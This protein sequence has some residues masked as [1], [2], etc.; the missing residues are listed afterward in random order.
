VQPDTT[1][2]TFIVA[3]VLCLVCS[4]LVS[5]AA[6]GL[7]PIQKRNQQLKLRRNV[8]V[9]AGMWQDDF[10]N[11][12]VDRAFESIKTVLVNLPRSE[13]IGEPGTINTEFNPQTY[14]PRKASND[15]ELR[16][17]I[18]EDL[19]RAGIKHREPVARVFLVMDGDQVDQIVLPVY[20]KGL[21]S[22][23]YGFLSLDADTRTVHGIT[24]YE[25]GETPGLGGEVENPVWKAKWPGKVALDDNYQ[26]QIDVVKG[27]ASPGSDNQIDGLSGATITSNGVEGLVDYWLGDDGFGPFLARFRDGELN[28]DDGS[29]SPASVSGNR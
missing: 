18:P 17:D 1:K 15:P 3:S 12:D 24:F 5:A 29:P 13:R 2:G 26:P 7:R 28:L 14:D 27:A 19:D 22:T 23:L 11:K 8:L 16:V 9:A 4:L 10:T 20:G 6:V 25:Q 21:W